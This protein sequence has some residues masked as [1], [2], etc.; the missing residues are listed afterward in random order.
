MTAPFSTRRRADEF[1]ALVS[2]SVS[3]TPAAPL[4]E[5]DAERFA[6]LLEVVEDLRALPQVAPRPEFSA[7]L[8]S[9][10]MAEADTVLLPVDRAIETRLT[11]VPST[12]TRP[13]RRL[14]AV[15]GGAAMVGAT[16]SVAVAAQSALPGDSLYPIKRALEGAET[17]IAASDASRGSRLLDNASGRLAEVD[18][19]A[20]RGT[21]EVAAQVPTTLT[22]FNEQ[23]RDAADVL[24][25]VYLETGDKVVITDLRAFT[26]RSMARLLDLEA[27]VPHGARDELVEAGRTLASIDE[28]AEEL[29]PSCEGGLSSLPAFLLAGRQA[30][31]GVVP[32]VASEASLDDVPTRVDGSGKVAEKGKGTRTEPVSTQSTDGL[33][34]PPIEIPE[35]TTSTGEEST[36]T[37]T[38]STPSAKDPVEDVTESLQGK[39]SVTTTLTDP[40][41]GEDGLL[42]G[43][44]DVVDDVTGG[45]TSG[46]LP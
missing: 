34:V 32:S 41:T 23:A 6:R 20:R 40:V 21:P 22:D 11:P 14:A 45:A 15:L 3:R 7:D 42:D 8:R 12:G 18:E 9:R 13:Q 5:R 36:K 10:L 35:Q 37:G 44:G 1:E 16:A 46:L 31:A 4:T 33:Q 39:D 38:G 25:S 30:A 28:R 2:G 29:C 24:I 43:G 26:S 27:E 19:L 17:S